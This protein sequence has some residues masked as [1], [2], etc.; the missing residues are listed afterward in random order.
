[1]TEAR[2]V[3]QAIVVL[4]GV[5]AGSSLLTLLAA[6]YLWPP[7]SRANDRGTC[8]PPLSA[9]QQQHPHYYGGHSSSTPEPPYQPQPSTSQP[10]GAAG[11][12]FSP[13]NTQKRPDPYDARPRNT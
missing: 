10:G 11:P 9:Q 7:R 13:I 6:T 12:L 8:R 2:S 1:M 4:A 3:S 5:A